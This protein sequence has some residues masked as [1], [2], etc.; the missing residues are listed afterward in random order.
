MR[1]ADCKTGGVID[2]AVS[3]SR[4]LPVRSVLLSTLLG[5]EPPRMPVALLVR[6]GQLF[7]FT[8]GAVR[9]SL[10][11]MAQRGEVT[12]TDGSYELAGRLVARQHR[13]AESRSAERGDWSGRWT[14]AVVTAEGR[15]APERASLRDAMS[16]LRLAPQ[17]EGVWT[18]PD[19]L[20]H[21]RAPEARAVAEAQCAWWVGNPLSD[22]ADL[23]AS[24]W[25]LAEWSERATLLRREMDPLTRRLEAQDEGALADGF[26]LSAAVLRHF[27]ADP[28]LPDELLPRGWPGRRLRADYDRFDAAYRDVLARWLRAAGDAAGD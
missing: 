5:T 7:G 3:G 26:V 17:R 6:V 1:T 12:A 9:T 21:D 27:Q 23:A 14:L 15:S 13:Q 22:D 25:P 18:R 16:H 8:E 2:P 24:L 11:R 4:P 19:N 20:P 28:L 10:T